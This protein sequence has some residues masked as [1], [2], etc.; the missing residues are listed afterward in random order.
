MPEIGFF[1]VKAKSDEIPNL[2]KNKKELY[3]GMPLHSEISNGMQRVYATPS[4]S[5]SFVGLSVGCKT[6]H[7]KW[8][9][10]STSLKAP[11]MLLLVLLILV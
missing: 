10:V 3:V 11:I 2:E 6:G 7:R 8:K 5:N 4:T 1:K 9:K